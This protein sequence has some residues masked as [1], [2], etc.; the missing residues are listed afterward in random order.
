MDRLVPR[1]LTPDLLTTGPLPAASVVLPLPLSSA[2]LVMEPCQ[3]GTGIMW[4]AF[5]EPVSAPGKAAQHAGA[6]WAAC[7]RRHGTPE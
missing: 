3:H 4:Y 6:R 2:S 7:R 5:A 1:K